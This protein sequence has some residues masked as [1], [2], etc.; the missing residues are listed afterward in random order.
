MITIG[1]DYISF[2]FPK[3]QLE[4]FET[5]FIKLP[6]ASTGRGFRG[7]KSSKDLLFGG[8]FAMS[9]DRDE[10]HFD[11]PGQA[12][13]YYFPDTWEIVRLSGFIETVGGKIS[14]YDI[15][16]DVQDEH[17]VNMDEVKRAVECRDYNSR[18][19]KYKIVEQFE[20]KEGEKVSLG[21][22][23]YIGSRK[24]QRL[25]RIYDKAK[26]QKLEGVEITRFE[27][28]SRDESAGSVANAIRSAFYESENGDAVREVILGLIRGFIDF[29]KNDNDTNATRKK[30]LSWWELIVADVKKIRLVRHKVEL[31]V[32]R[33]VLW[34][35]KQVAPTLNFLRSYYGTD[36]NKFLNEIIRIG[37]TRINEKMKKILEQKQCVLEPAPF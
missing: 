28:M 31:T 32:E 4:I 23:V 30:L 10:V 17:F 27:L 13:N 25:L 7:Y 8:K 21:R 5:D 15:N 22:T 26:E 14:R 36:F 37:G 16:L 2:T 3:N 20:W 9:D 35:E 11:L 24:S 18:A 33:A 19:T 29:V 12:V 1:C 34:I 6:V